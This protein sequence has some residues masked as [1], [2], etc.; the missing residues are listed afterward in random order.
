[1]MYKVTCPDCGREREVERAK[2]PKNSTILCNT[3]RVNRDRKRANEVYAEQ[4]REHQEWRDKRDKARLCKSR[5][6]L[7]EVCKMAKERHISYGKMSA[8]LHEEE[9]KRQREIAKKKEV[10]NRYDWSSSDKTDNADTLCD[11]G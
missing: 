2:K 10:Q 3:C 4:I 6:S 1:M 7:D 5:Y 9:V 11:V 8:M